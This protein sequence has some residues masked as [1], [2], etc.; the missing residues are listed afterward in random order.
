MMTLPLRSL[1]K[2]NIVK[3]VAVFVAAVLFT[4]VLASAG[5]EFTARPAKAKPTTS[6]SPEVS[7]PQRVQVFGTGVVRPV[8]EYAEMLK[9]DSVAEPDT[10]EQ[11]F[12]SLRGRI[13]TRQ[14]VE[15]PV[16]Q[17]PKPRV[18]RT[19]A[20]R[21]T[22]RTMDTETITPQGPVKEA[23][24]APPEAPV[25][26]DG[27]VNAAFPYTHL[28]PSPFN[29]PQGSWV[30]G[31][32][33]A[34]GVFDSLELST[35]VMRS[36][37]QQWNFQAKVPLIEYPTF[38][39]TAYVAFESNNPH[40][41]DDRNPDGRRGRWQPGLVTAYEMDDHMAFFLGGN[42]DFG[43]DEPP[44]VTTS[45][46]LKG[47]RIEA[48]W[49]WLYNPQSSRLGRNAIS[50]GTTYDLTYEMFGFGLTHHWDTF[51]LGVHYTFAD[52]S[53]FLPIFGFQAA[54]S[55]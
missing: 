41:I 4:P 25:S 10:S 16:A 51:T 23:A 11:E 49:S 18:V 55:F 40:T 54:A 24:E 3:S 48:D 45:G 34:Y 43:A 9:E 33:L 52:Q 53:R 32:T 44:V 26:Y 28:L 2:P 6:E 17:P 29:L 38:M 36:V 15:A 47:A 30:F 8:E 27:R 42:F 5:L 20:P 22:P 31:S 37:Q 39:T 21:P 19:P 35:N 1:P 50:I 7:Y 12:E 13:R 46:Y 14:V